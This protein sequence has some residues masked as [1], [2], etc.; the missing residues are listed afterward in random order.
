MAS[1]RQRRDSRIVPTPTVIARRGTRSALP[2]NRALSRTV[3]LV[4]DLSRVRLPSDEPGSLN[5]ICPSR[6]DPQNLQIDPPHVPNLLLVFLAILL[7]IGGQPVWDVCVFGFHVD[8][9][10]Q[11]LLHEVTVAL[12]MVWAK[13]H[14]FVQVESHHLREIELRLAVQ[15]NQ[16]AI[17]PLRRAA[18]RQTQYTAG[19]ATHQLSDNLRRPTCNPGRVRVQ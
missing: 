18:G 16:L 2:K 13:P 9:V 17:G 5:A 10:K 11:A 12:R 6:A 15:A 7:E 19:F 4:S 3:S 14:I 8:V 1:N